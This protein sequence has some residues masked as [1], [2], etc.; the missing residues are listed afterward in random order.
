MVG[1][2]KFRKRKRDIVCSSLASVKT[3]SG[4]LSE[5][6]APY[7]EL[8]M[9]GMDRRRNKNQVAGIILQEGVLFKEE[10]ET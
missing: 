9:E 8:T 3:S 1:H 2:N 10:K 7:M 4:L 6:A 5:S